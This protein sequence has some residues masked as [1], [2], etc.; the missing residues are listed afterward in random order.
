MRR[1]RPS[2]DEKKPSLDPAAQK[3]LEALKRAADRA[4]QAPK[5]KSYDH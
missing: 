3:A 1:P 4:A 5:E 2:T